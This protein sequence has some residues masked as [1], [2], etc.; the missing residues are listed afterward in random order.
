MANLD[1]PALAADWMRDHREGCRSRHQAWGTLPKHLVEQIEDHLFVDGQELVGIIDWGDAFVTDSYY[2]LVALHLGAF[3]ADTRLLHAFL[4]GYG[5][6]VDDSFA[7][8]ATNAALLHMHDVFAGV[9]ETARRSPTLED[10][11]ATLW[12]VR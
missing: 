2:D 8:R 10:L 4:R 12:D 9:A 7:L 6:T 5:W 3:G 1:P 11:A